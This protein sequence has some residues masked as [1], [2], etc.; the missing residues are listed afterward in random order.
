LEVSPDFDEAKCGLA[1]SLSAIC[2]FRG[3]GGSSVGSIIDDAGHLVATPSRS[4]TDSRPFLRGWHTDMVD[5][6]DRQTL[7]PYSHNIGL[8]SAFRQCDEWIEYAEFATGET[9]EKNR[10]QRWI[11]T[12]ERFYTDF[13]RLEERVNEGGLLIR[14]LEFF[15]RSLQRKWFLTRYGRLNNSSA[16]FGLTVGNSDVDN[17]KRPCPPSFM[18]T[19]SIPTV[20]PFHTVQLLSL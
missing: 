19:P 14:A 1:G 5:V 3:R 15:E 9:F 17:F 10:R 12:F 6:C 16:K 8:V 20:L 11:R 13:D 4:H 7:V 18:A 2:D